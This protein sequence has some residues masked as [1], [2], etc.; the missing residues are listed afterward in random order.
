MPAD[1]AVLE[2]RR[3]CSDVQFN[4]IFTEV[5]NNMV[6]IHD[7]EPVVV[8]GVQQPPY[9]TVDKVQFIHATHGEI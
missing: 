3:L 9:D 2:L 4:T 1:S 7:L 5:N 6:V 8:P